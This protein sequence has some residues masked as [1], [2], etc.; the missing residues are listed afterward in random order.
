MTSTPVILLIVSWEVEKHLQIIFMK[1][2]FSKKISTMLALSLSLMIL[3]SCFVAKDSST[4]ALGKTVIIKS[5]PDG[6]TILYNG[7]NIGATP[8]AF[9]IGD[10]YSL[11]DLKKNKTYKKYSKNKGEAVNKI[12]QDFS[13]NLTFVKDGYKIQ[14]FTLSPIVEIAENWAACF[15]GVEYPNEYNI[16]LKKTDDPSAYEKD[17]TIVAGEAKNMVSRDNPG[18]TALERTII[19]WYFDSE[20]RGARV[21]WRVISS[22]PSI[23]K[24]TNELYLGTTPYEDTRSFNIL[25]LTYE[26]SRDVQIEVK[27]TRPGYMD[28]VKRFNVRQAID[29]QEISSF[30]DLVKKDIE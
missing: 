24:N 2:G 30:F 5:V 21:F 27:L 10:Y 9:Q 12:K 18:G 29:Q 20:P 7:K 15:A 19:R 4:K 1:K 25:G 14:P 23:V 26:N 6:A 17:P 16:K 3:P 28:Q 8:Y 22:I 13:Y 11:I